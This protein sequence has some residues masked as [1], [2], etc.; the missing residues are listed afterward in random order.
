[1]RTCQQKTSNQLLWQGKGKHS[2]FQES[3]CVSRRRAQIHQSF[4]TTHVFPKPLITTTVLPS[5]SHCR[6]TAL[7]TKH[8]MAAQPS[9]MAESTVNYL[10]CLLATLLVHSP[11]HTQSSFYNTIDTQC[12]QQA[13]TAAPP[14]QDLLACYAAACAHTLQLTN[15]GTSLPP[16]GACWAQC[17]ASRHF[18]PL[19]SFGSEQHLI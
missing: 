13:T 4:L 12:L 17:P 10:P 2:N 5:S 16:S 9:P 11:P 3:I 15:P 18:L 8:T 1:M 6:G 7:K 14:A 19:L